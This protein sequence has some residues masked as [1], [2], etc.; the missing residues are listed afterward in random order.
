ME[1]LDEIIGGGMALTMSFDSRHREFS[2]EDW[3]AELRRLRYDDNDEEVGDEVV[4][5]ARLVRVGIDEAG[6]YDSLDAES[7]DLAEVGA[8][9]LD[10]DHIAEIDEGSLFASS[11]TI[12]DHVEVAAPNRGA[13][14]SLR[15][16]RGIARIFRDD[17]IALVPASISA[18][19]NGDL[20]FDTQ[21]Q[22]GLRRHW[23]RAGFVLVPGTDVMFLPTDARP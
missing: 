23:G 18:A 9:F 21:K 20:I 1:N 10:R 19:G 5:S 11:L 4:A 16:S 2:A 17:I 15:L 8:A 6:W 12:L 7:G 22:A 14:F 13:Q 3:S